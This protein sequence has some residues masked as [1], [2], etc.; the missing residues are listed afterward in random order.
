MK[1]T[2]SHSPAAWG[3]H[4]QRSHGELCLHL[5]FPHPPKL[6]GLPPG[7]RLS[8][9]RLSDALTPRRSD[10]LNITQPSVPTG[11]SQNPRRDLYFASRTVH[12]V[13]AAHRPC[14]PRCSPLLPRV[15]GSAA[16]YRRSDFAR[17]HQVYGALGSGTRLLAPE[18]HELWPTRAIPHVR[19]VAY[20]AQQTRPRAAM[21]H[22]RHPAQA[23]D[24][25]E[26]PPDHRH[27]GE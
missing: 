4:P 14:G 19:L 9:V 13:R 26:P 20:S 16:Q 11:Y 5:H 7:L 1:R 2:P 10:A 3:S 18:S 17:R 6:G 8:F 27:R 15:F 24:H 23:A 22:A 12:F 25:G 21:R